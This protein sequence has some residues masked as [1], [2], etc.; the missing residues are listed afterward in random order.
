MRTP[1]IASGV[2]EMPRIKQR[3]FSLLTYG[4]RREE[5][6]Q[7]YT[8]LEMSRPRSAAA[9]ILYRYRPELEIY[10]VRRAPAMMFQGGFHAF[11]GRRPD[12]NEKA[13]VCAAREPHA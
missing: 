9:I 1:D 6:A 2:E 12:P 10:W 11:P 4:F 13:R 8:Q 5:S 3:A 7:V